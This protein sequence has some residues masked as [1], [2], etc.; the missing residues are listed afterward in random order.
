[1]NSSI[2]N[3]INIKSR[4]VSEMLYDS[5]Q[6]TDGLEYPIVS[7]I[8][9]LYNAESV[10]NRCVDSI[11]KQ[12]FRDFELLLVD[13]GS[14]DFSGRI[15]DEYAAKDAR[16]HVI[17]KENT[18]VSDS[19]NIAI[20]KARG[21]YLQ[22]VDSDDW[23]T[24][25]ATGLL[26]SCAQTY[27]CDLVV[28]DFYRVVDNRIAHKGSIQENG[29]LTREKFASYMMEKPADFY[30]GVLWNKLYKKALIEQF[31]LE[32]DTEISW[33]ED[34]MFNL[35][36][37]SHTQNIYVLRVPIYYYVKTK[38]S[39]SAQG[40]SLTK[41]IKMKTMVFEYYKKFYKEVFDEKDYEKS[42]LQVYSFFLDAANDGIVPPV[43]LP[44][45]ARLGEER[46]QINPKVLENDT[47]LLDVYLKRKCLELCLNPITFRYDL[48]SE[49]VYL[50]L[51]LSQN[52]NMHTRK[53]LADFIG[54][55]QRKL[56]GALQRLKAHGY[57]TW[58]E[59]TSRDKAS[60]STARLLDIQLLPITEPILHELNEAQENYRHIIFSGF[61]ET[62]LNEYEELSK[63]LK[64]NI[65]KILL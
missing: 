53:E 26:L 38:H 40:I 24:P 32:M 20:R 21:T 10:I 33:C 50:L 12:N 35:E 5:Q 36:Y 19:R 7:I 49:E 65:I 4:E 52:H 59:H 15:C 17:H 3:I 37:I 14:Q 1:M 30:Y 48:Q 25:E 44:G 45:A 39:L 61:S 13:D 9:P 64:E 2:I 41:T 18:G 51:F 16:V 22:F 27:P 55:P 28:S 34:F 60:K 29:L 6:E 62:E 42:R 58:T 31:H 63:R 47:T 46:V 8:V 56:N 11:L 54:Q 43:Q 23:L 57:L